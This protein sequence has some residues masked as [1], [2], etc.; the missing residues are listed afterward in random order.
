M[1][2]NMLQGLPIAREFVWISPPP[3]PCSCSSKGS[4]AI[5]SHERGRTLNPGKLAAAM[6]SNPRENDQGL[7]LL[8]MRKD[9]QTPQDT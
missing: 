8:G 5:E 9:A 7:G 1:T 4:W 6:E 2:V 3:P